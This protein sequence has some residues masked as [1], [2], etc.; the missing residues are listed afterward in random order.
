MRLRR[1]ELSGFKSFPGRSTVE[2]SGGVT[3]IV[4]PNG[5]GKS[6]LVDAIR[7]VLGEQSPKQLRGGAM[8]DVLFKGSDGCPPAHVAEVSLTFEN[9]EEGWTVEDGSPVSHLLKNAAELTVTRRYYRDGEGEYLINKVPC[10]LRDITELI[11]GNGIA[12]PAYAIIE[13]GRVEK[14]V[15]ARP[16]ERRLF[17]EEAAGTSLY[18]GR[19]LAAQRRMERTRENLARVTD[20]LR[21]LDRQIAYFRRLAKRS[22]QAQVLRQELR[23]RELELAGAQRVEL[24]VAEAR[25]SERGRELHDRLEEN[26]ARL[27]RYREALSE[28]E[29]QVGRQRELVQDLERVYER[30]ASELGA[31][32]RERELI[33]R[34]T[35]EALHKL[36]VI[37][38][39][40]RNVEQDIE[41]ASMACAEEISKSRRIWLR[42]LEAERHLAESK[43]REARRK[44]AL[45]RVRSWLEALVHQEAELWRAEVEARNRVERYERELHG[46]ERAMASTGAEL[47]PLRKALLE[48]ERRVL[49]AGARLREVEELER[50]KQAELAEREQTLRV[51]VETVEKQG[52]HFDQLRAE[53]VE[54]ES[55]LGALEK[56]RETYEGFNPS[57]RGLLQNSRL[58][59]EA[60]VL[61]VVADVLQVPADWEGAVAAALGGDVQCLIVD[62]VEASIGA[63]AQLEQQRQGRARF[64]P[65]RP[66]L[67]TPAREKVLSLNGASRPLLD[68]VQVDPGFEDLAVALLGPVAV[69]PD[70]TEGVRLWNEAGGDIM[71]VTPSGEAV[72]RRGVISGGMGDEGAAQEIL[73]RRRLLAEL[74]SLRSNLHD[75]F[76]AARDR[77]LESKEQRE[78][79]QASYEN[80]REEAR[81]L[82]ATLAGL[83]EELRA[84]EGEWRRLAERFEERFRSL[85]R[86]H[87]ERERIATALTSAQ[88][89]LAKIQEEKRQ[90]RSSELLGRE[91]Q[92]LQSALDAV[93]DELTAH[94]I[95]VA[96]LCREYESC[97]RAMC[98][99]RHNRQRLLERRGMLLREREEEKRAESESRDR[100]EGLVR[101][102]SAIEVK[103]TDISRTIADAKFQLTEAQSRSAALEAERE[104]LERER[105]DLQRASTE[106]EVSLAECRVKLAHVLQDVRDK[107]GLPPSEWADRCAP[108]PETEQARIRDRIAEI[109]NALA[110]LGEAGTG[111]WE[112]LQDAQ[113]RAEF[114]RKQ[115]G[116][117]E[118]S[119]QDLERTIARL[120]AVS[121]ERFQATFEQ[122]VAHF[123][124]T[125]GHLFPGADAR[126]VLTEGS[127]SGEPGVDIWVRLPGKRLESISLLSGGEKA[128][129][130]VGLL[131]ALFTVNPTPFCILDEVDA[132]LDDANVGRFVHLVREMSR[133]AQMLVVTHNKRTMEAADRLYGVT[134]G[135]PGVSSVLAISLR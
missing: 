65:V 71:V 116:D 20:I 22:E 88:W 8:E 5:C 43:I 75:R 11:A 36:G 131:F 87:T 3:A 124:E 29:R 96:E 58:R 25:L 53:L 45:A 115:K 92:R 125:V 77:Y 111:V 6:N 27:E 59:S 57:V 32:E 55:R 24:E 60:R 83:K 12:G 46:V 67:R 42:L 41:A 82:G 106:A 114:L 2:F 72:D 86:L 119:L 35:R 121:K 132:P 15:L 54:V 51:L 128:L 13:Q 85:S 95:R 21:E 79:A 78:F 28:V 104:A 19:R 134:M 112:D 26:S 50:A 84:Q 123:R 73:A 47:E 70:L 110:R 49:C 129:V 90:T 102:R 97:I 101:Q 107:Y 130:A 80:A 94:G 31:V 23:D 89:E 118:A 117:L 74:A 39:Q 62:S 17:I 40:I 135:T 34:R 103:I 105:E 64:I 38:Q 56:L 10:R 1:L 48:V 98:A 109:R 4:G 69:A 68:F 44:A 81:R 9:P 76:L 61:G 16:E 63:I 108:L 120:D 18:R 126:L 113:A 52:I 99:V 14:L 100:V 66:S 133:R 127:E 122:V 91:A 93:R 37:D 33:E 30:H 7:W